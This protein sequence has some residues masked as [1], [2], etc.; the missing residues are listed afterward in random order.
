MARSDL[1]KRLFAAYSRGDDAGFRSAATAIV[2][3]ER[4]KQHLLLASEL[5]HALTRDRKPG[6]ATPLTMRPLPKGRDERPLLALTKPAHELDDLVLAEATRCLLAELIAEN[7]ARSVLASHGL[8]P[9]QRLLFVGPSGTG[10]SASAHA[11]A[12]ELSYP[13]ATVSLA[14]LTSSFLGETARNVEAIIRFA[15]GTP[16]VLLFDEFDAVGSERSAGNDHSE[17]RRVV[18]TVLQLFEQM[19]GESVLIATSNH[20]ALLDAAVWR[21]FDEVAG[22]TNLDAASLERLI[23]LKLH[24]VPHRISVQTWATKLSNRTPAEAEAACLD[25]LRRW[26]MSGTNELSDD[27]MSVAVDRVEQRGKLINGVAT[28]S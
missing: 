19:H 14:A 5:E 3:D 21:R 1:L 25:A 28:P 12:A 9:R 2:D 13:V 26:A 10:K 18:A 15:E 6:A 16:C 23:E 24:A 17:L 22:F 7:R 8:K 20:A 4:R 27:V 11:I